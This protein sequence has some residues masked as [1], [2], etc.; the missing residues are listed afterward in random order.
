M[1][2]LP[3]SDDIA[4]SIQLSIID[5]FRTGQAD[6]EITVTELELGRKVYQKENIFKGA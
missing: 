4:R 5:E 3:L 1:A 2:A 6:V